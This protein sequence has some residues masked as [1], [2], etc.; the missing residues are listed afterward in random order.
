MEQMVRCP[1]CGSENRAGQPFCGTCGTKLVTGT[2][3]QKVKCPNCGS[4]NLAGQQ[5]CG[6]CGA[7]LAVAAPQAPAA[8]TQVMPTRAVSPVAPRQHLEVKP[9]WGLA[10]GLW[11]R[12][13]LLGLLIG[14][15][16]YLM[17]MIVMVLGFGYKLPLGS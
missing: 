6:I 9:T 14:G 11:W 2:Q 13:L 16:V 8:E 1:N 4:Q 5:F 12:M 3:Q 7:K 15:I 17:A 10:W